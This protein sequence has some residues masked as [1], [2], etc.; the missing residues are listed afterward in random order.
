MN[1]ADFI[2]ALRT[3]PLHPGAAG[4]YDDTAQLGDLIL[5][6]DMVAQGVHY[7]P[8]DPAR[9][10]AWKLMAVN[11]SD[12]AAKGAEPVGA[13]LG[14][15]LGDDDWDRDFLTG[16]GEAAA[17]FGCPLLGGDTIRVDG[18]RVLS[19]TAI[20]RAGARVPVRG[21]A[22]A[23]D[24]LWVAGVVGDAALGLSIAQGEAGPPELLAAYRRPTP[25][26][27]EGRAIARVATAMMDVSDGLLID[28]SRMGMAS[29]CG[30][31]I[32]LAA[33]PRSRAACAHAGT[34]RAARLRAA[35]GGD[36]YALLFALPDGTAPPVPAARLGVFGPGAGL[37]LTDE[38][39][40][41]DLPKT[42]GWEHAAR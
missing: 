25:L 22:Q 4:L 21:G 26:L 23:G 41:V 19:L 27:R 20:G 5:T 18:P 36:D 8:T 3:L 16:L 17:A 34:D 29:G 42:L 39:Q 31:A 35:T 40:A 7:L 1:E 37:H 28:A 9:D 15:P 13:L 14:Y 10:V 2:A 12:L 32:D 6:K 11:L 24:V 38:G 30:V 33:V